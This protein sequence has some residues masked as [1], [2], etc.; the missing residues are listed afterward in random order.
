MFQP[1]QTQG[2]RPQQYSYGYPASYYSPTQTNGFDM[3][4]MMNMI[5]MVMMMG[6]MMSMLKPIMK[7]VS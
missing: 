7:G 6:I 3:N 5:M 2:F 1:Q 4:A